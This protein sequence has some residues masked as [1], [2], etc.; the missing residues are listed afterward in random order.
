MAALALCGALAVLAACGGDPGDDAPTVYRHAM[1]NKADSVDPARAATVYANHLVLNLYDTLYAYRYLAR[2]YDLKPNLAAAM[3]EISA[4]GLTYTIPLKPGVFFIDDPAF[5]ASGGEGREVVAQDVVYSIER[6]LDPATNSLGAWLWRNRLERIEAL[7]RYTVR[8]QLARPFPQ[9]LHTLA[10]GFAAIMPR[11]AVV[12]Y[13]AEIGVHAVGSGPFMLESLDAQ[14]AVLVANPD[15]R[16][17][18]VDLA[19]EGYEE[20]LHGGLGLEAIE[21]RSPP[22]VDRVEILFVAEDQARWN[23][24]R[25]GNEVHYAR[26]PSDVLNEVLE[27]TD[28]MQLAPAFAQDYHALLV[29]APEVVYHA[30]NFDFAEIGYNA[31][32]EREARNRLLR[33]ALVKAF[34]WSARDKAFFDGT[35]AIF[36]G[37]LP[38]AVPEYDPHVPREAVEQDVEA[39]RAM[40]REGGW[41]ENNLPQLEYAF[42]ATTTQQQ[43]FEQFRAWAVQIGYPLSKILPKPYA[44]FGDFAGAMRRGELMLSLKSWSL[45]YPD[46]ENIMQVFYGPNRAPGS[47]DANYANDHYDALYELSA[48]MA[49]GPER[50]RIVREMNQLLVDD[51]AVIAGL[52]RTQLLMWRDDVI[53][54]PDRNTVG[55]FALKYVAFEEAA[56]GVGDAAGEAAGARAGAAPPAAG[57]NR[58][59][60][61]EVGR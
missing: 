28:P 3:P 52:A 11:E 8:I 39:A 27:A 13:G 25:K 49:P 29:P 47:N 59:S 18:P 41:D 42:N 23:S 14:R 5:A 4:D 60:E 46:A 58:G 61:G 33:C 50:T 55:G 44:S 34:D 15:Y 10:Q 43:F 51:C 17:E 22:F 19:A 26:A 7:D 38:P 48:G 9:L 31:D 36:P 2:P 32:P 1:D 37:M 21:G 40:L 12:H 35:S 30:F 56:E 20:S 57:R 53:F 45:D 54:Y 24:F 6:Q 16:R